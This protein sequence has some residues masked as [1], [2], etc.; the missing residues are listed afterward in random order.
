VRKTRRNNPSDKGKLEKSSGK[1]ESTRGGVNL[2]SLKE[3]SGVA[4][5]RASTWGNQKGGSNGKERK[6]KKKKAQRTVRFK[7]KAHKGRHR[8]KEEEGP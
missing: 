2:L 5:K 7:P 8:A 4:S 6:E 1:R 3:E